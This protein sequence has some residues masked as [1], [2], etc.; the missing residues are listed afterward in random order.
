MKQ[1]LVGV[2]IAALGVAIAIPEAEAKRVGGARSSGAQRSVTSTPPSGP[3]VR[4]CE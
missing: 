2:A 3:V 1:W 4:P